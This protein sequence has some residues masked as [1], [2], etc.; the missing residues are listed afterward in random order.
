[1]EAAS[2]GLP[3]VAS[4]CGISNEILKE[5]ENGFLTRRG[6]IEEMAKKVLAIFQDDN[7]W[8]KTSTSARALAEKVNDPE[9]YRDKWCTLL[10]QEA[11]NSCSYLLPPK[12]C[13]LKRLFYL[14]RS[15]FSIC[16]SLQYEALSELSLEGKVLD[17]GGYQNADYLKLIRNI[18]DVTSVNINPKLKPTLLADLNQPLPYQDEGFDHVI[19]LNT[20]E[21]VYNDKLMLK[22]AIRVLK[23]GGSFFVTIPFIYRVHGS[24]SDFHR[25]THHYWYQSLLDLGITSSSIKI[26][27]LVWS[28]T[29][30]A[31]SLVDGSLIKRLIRPFAL[32]PGLFKDSFE[33]AER[34]TGVRKIESRSDYAVGFIIRATK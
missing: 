30:T 2:Y 26:E 34:I 29:A 23:K 32:L 27:P 15:K 21:H 24:P 18:K 8:R 16:R 11:D 19:S 31:F 25:H 12:K 1:L 14:S 6:D 4:E 3:V 20:F 13:T 10:L 7:L 33:R 9:L 28:R 5:G 22:E 17:L